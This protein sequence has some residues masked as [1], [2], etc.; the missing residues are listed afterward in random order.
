MTAHGSLDTAVKALQHGALEYLP[1]PFDID[2][3]KRLIESALSAATPN[4]IVEELRR[5]ASSPPASSGDRPPCR[6]CSS[7][8]P[9]LRPPTPTCF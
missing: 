5:D 3:V 9:P 7:R 2:Q 8:W 4:R 6:S 1:K